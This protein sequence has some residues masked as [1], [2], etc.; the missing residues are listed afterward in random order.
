[1]AARRGAPQPPGGG[2]FAVVVVLTALS[3]VVASSSYNPTA[4]RSGRGEDNN[5]TISLHHPQ[6]APTPFPEAS[7]DVNSSGS[8]SNS[9]T[10]S[11]SPGSNP[12]S[13]A[14]SRRGLRAF[15]GVQLFYSSAGDTSPHQQ[16]LPL[17]PTTVHSILLT[18]EAGLVTS[19]DR[20]GSHQLVLLTIR[21]TTILGLSLPGGVRLVTWTMPAVIN[22]M[23][24]DCKI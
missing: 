17:P 22:W 5:K 4:I 20:T 3:S 2:M 23:C 11:P 16:P 7:D 13:P 9:G 24:F 8:G 6:W 1:M 12:R 14:S 19:S 10:L 15:P 18:S 21:P